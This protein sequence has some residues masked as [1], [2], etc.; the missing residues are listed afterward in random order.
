MQVTHNGATGTI[1]NATG[2]LAIK[3][4]ATDADLEF[5]ADDGSGSPTKYFGL[6]GGLV[7]TKFLKHTRHVDGV[8]AYFGDDNDLLV[9]H[10]GTIGTIQAQTGDIQFK[11]LGSASDLTFYA[12]STMMLSL[13]G[14]REIVHHHR[15]VE[16]NTVLSNNSDYTVGTANHIILM[17]NMSA[18]RTVTIAT[19]ECNLGRVL[20]IKDRDGQAAMHN[21]TIATQGSQTIDGA[22]TKVIN[23][24][25]G[26][27]TLV[28]DGTNWS[29]I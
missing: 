27:V 22:A 26:S 6:D 8:N 20:I 28:C 17:H 21:I 12:A 14:G 19:S 2:D 11:A 15:G 29:T 25:Y 16:Y 4:T 7:L 3:A 13:D 1:Q 5:Y 23:S 9:G 10:N 18:G 24:G